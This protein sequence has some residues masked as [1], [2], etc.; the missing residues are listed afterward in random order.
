ML[1]DQNESYKLSIQL[2]DAQIF[3]LKEII[4]N[5]KEYSE[6]I[7]DHWWQ[8]PIFDVLFFIGGFISATLTINILR[9][10]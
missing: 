9:G 5:Y 2:K 1:R 6:A 7:G 10:T 3:D 4:K 8:S